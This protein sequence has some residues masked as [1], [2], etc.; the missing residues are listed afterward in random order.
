MKLLACAAKHKVDTYTGASS[1]N[2][3]NCKALDRYLKSLTESLEELVQGVPTP[4]RA[5][6]E[7]RTLGR[8]DLSAAAIQSLAV[9]KTLECKAPRAQ[10]EAITE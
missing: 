2:L 8:Y 9:E 1:G 5:F 10:V 6:L 3:K 7:I 4:D